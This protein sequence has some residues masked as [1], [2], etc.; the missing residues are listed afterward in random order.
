MYDEWWNPVYVVR[1]GEYQTEIRPNQVADKS[2]GPRSI[3]DYPRI[4]NHPY[5]A[6]NIEEISEQKS[7]EPP[8]PLRAARTRS[9]REETLEAAIDRLTSECKWNEKEARMRNLAQ[10]ALLN[11]EIVRESTARL[12]KGELLEIGERVAEVREESAREAR[13]SETLATK[14]DNYFVITDDRDLERMMARLHEECA[15]QRQDEWFQRVF[16]WFDNTAIRRKLL[17]RGI[18]IPLVQSLTEWDTETSGVDR[19]IDLTGG[20]SFWLPLLNEGYYVAYGHLTGDAQCSREAALLA[21]QAFIEDAAQIKAYHNADFDLN[22]HLNDGFQPA[23]IRYCSMDGYQVLSGEEFAPLKETVAKYKHRLDLPPMDDYAFEDLFGNVSPMLFSPEVVGIYAIKDVHKG[24]AFT[25]WQINLLMSRDRL[26][27][28]YAEIRQYLIEVNANIVRTG[29]DIDLDEL[30]RLSKEYRKRLE[31][32]KQAIFDAYKIDAAFLYDMSMAIKGE[33]INAWCEQKRKKIANRDDM[34]AK[35]R[36]DLA[37]ANPV[38]KKYADLRRRIERYE[39]EVL[40][41]PIP[42]NAPDFVREFNLDSDDHLA[43][44]IYDRLGI[45]DRTGEIDKDKNKRR[46]VSKDV[47]A[48]YYE[49]EPSLKPLAEYAK[50]ATLLG[51]FV[52]KIPNALDVDG[53]LHTQL[54]VAQTARYKSKSY[55]GKPFTSMPQ[56]EYLEIMRTLVECDRKVS[57][58]TNLQ[59]IPARYDEGIRVRMAF[60]P[61]EGYRFVGSDL[62]SIEPR[63]Q[64]HRMAVEFGDQIFADMYRQGLD[65]YVE[66][67]S[68]LFEVARELCVEKAYK[69]RKGTPGEIPPYR[70]AM[71]ELFLARGYGQ[72]FESFAKKVRQYGVSDAQARVAYDKFAE[73]L[74]GFQR[75]VEATFAILREREFA[76]NLWGQK[77]RF[78]EYKARWNRLCDLMRKVGIS[79]KNDPELAKK[80]GKLKWEERS[81]FWDLIRK[82][83]AA[84]REAFNHTIQSSG[85]A[86]LQQNMIMFYYVCVIGRGWLFHLTLHDELKHG[87]PEDQ[88][89]PEAIELY[90]DI[91]TTTVDLAVP[92][93]TDTVI[94]PRWMEEYSPDEW[95]FENCRP[96]PEFANK[97]DYLKPKEAQPA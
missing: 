12:T 33:K 61:R 69:E 37:A 91:M 82:T 31:K 46:G 6:K 15:L 29:F 47:L 25:K 44:L 23:G 55:N 2:F 68:I 52:E 92:L 34:L 89:T 59:N 78:P 75:M 19:F 35:C 80:S 3:D 5:H 39:T 93:E 54:G 32:A 8:K 1:D 97:Y 22:M 63:L 64:A 36:T 51:T 72:A 41:E 87:I 24:W 18:E 58:G 88:L 56:G 70:K 50:F 28:A 95:D 86:V 30:V 20:Y 71:K 66:F 53:R 79:D 57:K 85:A 84:E 94:E 77:R 40:A 4:T 43:Y 38:T 10:E 90:A 17:E 96:L 73:I 14:P 13:I 42:Q 65:P 21:V 60:I 49:E 74:P 83:G 9:Q 76:E 81:E 48:A 27:V 45:K 11:G 67:A 7:Q 62:S 26:G 16:S